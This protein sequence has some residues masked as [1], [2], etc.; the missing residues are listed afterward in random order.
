MDVT[1]AR[2]DGNR[3]RTCVVT[4]RDMRARHLEILLER[5]T[6]SSLSSVIGNLR[7]RTP[8][9]C[10]T[11]FATAPAV[12]VIPIS[13]THLIPSA[14]TCGSF[15]S[16]RIASIDVTSAFTGTWY[17][18]RLAFIVRPEFGS[19]TACSCSAKDTPHIMPPRYWLCT[20]L[21]L[22]IRP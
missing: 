22:M 15:S 20:S 7:T 11:A 14:L 18:A 9:A 21:G 17:S 13:Q 3:P 2:A 6:H 1:D 10:Q 16:T 19:M 12:P 5:Y 4:I 8:V